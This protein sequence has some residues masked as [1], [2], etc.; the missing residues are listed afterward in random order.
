MI[1]LFAWLACAWPDPELA[2]QRDALDAWER[3]RAAL[4]AGDP[5][6]AREAFREAARRR[7]GDV[8]L[9]AWE[10]SAAAAAGDLHDAIRLLDQVL[11]KRPTFHEARYNRAAY[12]ARLGDAARAADDLETALAS[13]LDRPPR[14]VIADPDFAAYVG[15]PE[16]AFLPREP[17]TV[18][19]ERPEGAV[20]WGSL[21]EIRLRVAGA[22]T[23][24]VGV[25]AE[26]V[27]GPIELVSVVEDV[28]PSTNPEFRDLTWTFRVLG[29]GE[30]HLGPFHVLAGKR[31][32]AVDAITVVARAPEGKEQPATAPPPIRFA[33]PRELAGKQP[34]GTAWRHADGVT[35]RVSPPDRVVAGPET[36]DYERIVRYEYRDKGQPEWMLLVF[37]DAPADFHVRISRGGNVVYEGPA[38]APSP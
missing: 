9:L 4:D 35:V 18:A 24:P 36:A 28:V 20:F 38:V 8:E 23:E 7:P 33:T 27:A 30:I 6:A 29:A 37:P 2:A 21:F 17:L 13:G 22:G 5:A 1:W 10:A 12:H 34:L 19:V 14:D 25:T 31:A 15:T 11:D 26:E 16:F 3:G 32:V